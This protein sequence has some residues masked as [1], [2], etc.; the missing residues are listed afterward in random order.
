MSMR[1]MRDC[2]GAPEDVHG[3]TANERA[4]I[5]FLRLISNGRDP[6]PRLRDVQLLRRL[7]QRRRDQLSQQLLQ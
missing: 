5:G 6:A 2:G 3:L 7:L 4:W 1:D